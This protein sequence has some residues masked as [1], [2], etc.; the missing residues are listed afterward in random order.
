M[1]SSSRADSGGAARLTQPRSLL[2]AEKYAG[3]APQTTERPVGTAPRPGPEKAVASS[4][5]AVRVLLLIR[6][7]QGHIAPGCPVCLG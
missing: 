5:N 7:R 3:L 1:A 2:Q 6:K 4:G